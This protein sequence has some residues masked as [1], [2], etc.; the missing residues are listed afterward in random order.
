MEFQKRLEEQEKVNSMLHFYQKG[1]KI[2]TH[3][4]DKSPSLEVIDY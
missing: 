3:K 1:L 2:N 4:N